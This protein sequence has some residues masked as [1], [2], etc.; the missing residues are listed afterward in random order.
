MSRSLL[1]SALSLNGG[2]VDTMGFVALHG[3]FTAHVTGNFV[4]LGAAI[5]TGTGGLLAKALALP[6]F[7]VSVMAARYFAHWL[8]KHDHRVVPVLL[9]LQFTLFLAA[10][11]LAFLLSLAASSPGEIIIGMTL[12]V[13]MAIQNAVH[14]VHLPDLPPSTL[15]TGT[16]TQIM[17]DLA[18][19]IFERTADRKPLKRRLKRLVPAL[20]LFALGCALAALAYR[21]FGRFCFLAPPVII[22]LAF[23][24][25]WL[26]D[27]AEKPAT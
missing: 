10:A 14:R 3:L 1:A 2:Y 19:L 6:V 11:I 13:A 25:Y 9:I 27:K 12:V 4:T 21:L 5:A 7:C 17:L 26:E 8:G 20:F 23:Y 22:M 18:D 16:T 15:M 24:A